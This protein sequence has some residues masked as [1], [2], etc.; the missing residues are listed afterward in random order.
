MAEAVQ[1][2]EHILNKTYVEER[3]NAMHKMILDN[4]AQ[5]G[6]SYDSNGNW[7]ENSLIDEK[8]RKKAIKESSSIK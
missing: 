4:E 8:I 7:I 5:H 3:Q 6:S 1:Q 2:Q